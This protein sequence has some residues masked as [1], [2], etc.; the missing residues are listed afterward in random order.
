ME[1]LGQT[2]MDTEGGLYFA[3]GYCLSPPLECKLLEHRLCVLH[4]L[5]YLQY[6]EQ[7]LEHSGHLILLIAYWHTIRAHVQISQEKGLLGCPVF[8]A[9]VE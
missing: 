9:S 8:S 6:L 1:V 3:S 7:C 5:P 2:H 4:V